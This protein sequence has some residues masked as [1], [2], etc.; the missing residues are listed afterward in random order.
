[1]GGWGLAQTPATRSLP[2]LGQ[3]TAQTTPAEWEHLPLDAGHRGSKDLAQKVCSAALDCQIGLIV[4]GQDLGWQLWETAW[5]RGWIGETK[6]QTQGSAG[7]LYPSSFLMPSSGHPAGL[8]LSRPQMCL[9]IPATQVL[10]I[11]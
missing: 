8:K 6:G 7:E 3:K 1:M 4:W 9:P 5:G 11:I 10:P 2:S